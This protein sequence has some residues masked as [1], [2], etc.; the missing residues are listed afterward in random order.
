MTPVQT[1]LTVACKVHFTQARH[2]RKQMAVGDF[3]GGEG[4]LFV[5]HTGELTVNAEKLTVLSKAVRPDEWVAFLQS[6]RWFSGKG[7]AIVSA[8]PQACCSVDSA[9]SVAVLRVAY[10]PDDHEDYL[11]P[12]LVGTAEEPGQRLACAGGS[13]DGGPRKRA[14][15]ATAPAIGHAAHAQDDI[16]GEAGD[17][18][19]QP[20]RKPVEPEIE[21]LEGTAIEGQGRGR[22]LSP[23]EGAAGAEGEQTR[24][25]A[26]RGEGQ[27]QP[28]RLALGASA[29]QD[30][31]DDDDFHCAGRRPAESGR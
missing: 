15:K 23:F 21:R 19:R 16:R 20:R 29:S 14:L 28:D 13:D 5:T 8:S 4:K 30:V 10:G 31:L 18:R 22:W 2:G 7:R 6:Q 17:R 25:V 27:R 1:S 26:G 3:L 12:L 11:I 9:L 24:A